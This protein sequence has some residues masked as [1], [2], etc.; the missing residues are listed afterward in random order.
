M[1]QRQ[2]NHLDL[3]RSTRQELV[4]P[5]VLIL[6]ISVLLIGALVVLAARSQDRVASESSIH[7]TRS[8]L[9]DIEQRLADQ[10][11]DYSYWNQAVDH[12]VNNFSAEWADNNVGIYMHKNFGI[13]SS[14]VIDAGNRTVY[15]MS[16][17]ARSTA[18]PLTRYGDDLETLIKRARNSPRTDPPVPAVGLLLDG[19]IIH[20]GAVGILTKSKKDLKP[21]SRIPSGWVLV[22]TR[23]LATKLLETISAKYLLDDLRLTKTGGDENTTGLPL[24]SSD[25]TPLGSLV[26][27][28]EKPGTEMLSW[29]L[30]LIGVVF[31]LMT[32]LTLAFFRRAN[33]VTEAFYEAMIAR[34]ETEREMERAQIVGHARKMEALGNMVGGITHNFNNL[35]LPIMALSWAT[36]ETLPEGSKER[37][38]LEKVVE[39]STDARN[40]VDQ[41][42]T[43]ARRDPPEM[44]VID[45]PPAIKSA[46]EL[47]RA[48]MPSSIELEERLDTGVGRI[49]GDE[50]QIQTILLN[51]VT[52]SVDALGGEPGKISVSLDRVGVSLNTNEEI[53]NLDEGSFARLTIADNGVGMDEKTLSMIFD[54]FFTTKDTNKG[55]G[56]GLSSAYGIVTEHGGKIDVSSTPGAGTVFKVYLPLAAEDP[57]R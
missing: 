16:D 46:L 51:M 48:T 8:I 1:N 17:G 41:I 20:I 32:G 44:K 47:A 35:L 9:K 10:L 14:Y 21:D 12:L 25:D 49:L 53:L 7:L 5:V 42:M 19:K 6:V 56:L 15:G 18:D 40:L 52:N 2:N 22:F 24:F 4:V 36:K 57:G 30:P 37:E 50:T 45:L 55:T 23:A 54:P 28:P 34:E 3:A 38:N 26:W 13:T 27:R 39:A 33:R 31:A 43:F 11:V 29:V